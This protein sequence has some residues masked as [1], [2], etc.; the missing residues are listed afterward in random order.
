MFL[1]LCLGV[2]LRYIVLI[3]TVE[4]KIDLVGRFPRA[5]MI[6]RDRFLALEAFGP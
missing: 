3:C 1:L 5:E 6:K 4:V 2:E